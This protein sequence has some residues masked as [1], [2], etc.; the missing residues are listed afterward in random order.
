MEAWLGSETGVGIRRLGFGTGDS[1][2]GIRIE[3]GGATVT[4]LGFVLQIH[5]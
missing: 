5:I 3:G 2:L 1:G 4:V